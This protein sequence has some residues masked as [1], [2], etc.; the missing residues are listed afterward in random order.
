M[1]KLNDL[2]CIALS[3]ASQRDNASLYPLP[4]I[5][6]DAGARLDKGL[7]A[8]IKNGLVEERQTSDIAQIHRNDVD[9]SYGL[10]LTDAGRVAIG[11]DDGNTAPGEPA[12]TDI[13]A[14][15]PTKT[16]TV[17]TLLQ[18]AE[19]ATLADLIAATGWLPHTTRAAL[20]GIRHK[21][22]VIDK[23]KA[24]GV[25]TYRIAAAEVASDGHQR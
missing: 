13:A 19:G 5:I 16:A 3:A 2:Q 15:L 25:T 9:A 21:G 1:T 10:F 17:L 8:L 23:T 20:T 7:A 11:V 6:A 24:D 14:T 22:H 18:R 12:V 4:D